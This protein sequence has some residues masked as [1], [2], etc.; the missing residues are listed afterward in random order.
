M[1]GTLI[2]ITNDLINMFVCCNKD[3]SIE[4]SVS[5][6][7]TRPYHRSKQQPC[8]PIRC[9]PQITCTLGV[10]LCRHGS[11]TCRRQLASRGRRA[12]AVVVVVVYWP[13]KISNRIFLRSKRSPAQ[14]EKLISSNIRFDI[15]VSAVQ[16]MSWVA[17]HDGI[18]MGMPQAKT[19][20]GFLK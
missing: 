12:V 4:A 3:Q 6:S 13:R 20:E 9:A 15:I 1:P 18:S 11:R 5:A 2:I 7:P 8:P 17:S 10:A 19:M 14:G 16:R